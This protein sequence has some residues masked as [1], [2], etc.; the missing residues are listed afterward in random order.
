[1]SNSIML[2]PTAELDPVEKQLLPR[3]ET[4]S[5]AT[6]GLLDIS[7]PRG[8]EFLDEI[9]KHLVEMGATVKRYM[10]PTFARVAPQELNQKIS[11]E[12][13]A[14]IEGLAD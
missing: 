11:V 9:E 12:C 3:L 10:K 4:L 2:D 8:K 6:V 14:V 5:G 1:M 7:K 13:D